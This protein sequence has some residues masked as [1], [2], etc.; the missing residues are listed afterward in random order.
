MKRLVL[1]ASTVLISLVC[2]AAVS[3]QVTNTGSISGSV[4]DP[5]GAVVAN[6]AV[7]AKNAET[8]IENSA[9]T[10][11]NGTFTI[12][13][14]E[15][16]TYRITVQATS[17]FKRTEITNV[18]VNV[19]S[20]TTVKVTMELGPPQETVTIVGGGE[21]LQTQ[22]ANVGSTITGRQ[23]TELPFTSRDALDLVLTL[24]GTQTPA[25]PRS[26]TINGLPKGALNITLDGLPD[27]AEDSKSSDG[28]FTFVR[29][30]I[31]AIEEVSLSSAVPGAE[32]SGDGA[33]QIKFS[34]R[35]G[36]SEYHGSAY[37]YHRNTALNANYYFNNISGQPRQA[38]LL[39]QPGGRVG[40][41][42]LIPKLLK[43]RDKAF[44]FVNYEEFRLPGSTARQRNVLTPD[45]QQGIFRYG[46]NSVN[47][48][49]L[50][51][52]KGQ[53]STIDPTIATN[54]SAIRASLS[55]GGLT[56]LGD[57]QQRFTWN[58]PAAQVR[59]F[60]TVRLDFNLT[61]KH[62]LD[63][64]WNYNVFRSS[65]D[66][67]NGRDPIF[68]G[69]GIG[70]GGQYSLR[71]SDSLGL[72]STLKPNL[73]NEF[74]AGIGTGGTVLF[75]PETNAGAFAPLGGFAPSFTV[76]APGGNSTSSIFSGS[77]SSRNNAPSIVFSDNVSYVRGEHSLNFGADYAQ[78]K[79]WSQN[80][81]RVVPAITFGLNTNDPAQMS[82]MFA[83]ANFPGASGTDI[84]NAQNLYA[85]LTGRVITIT[86]SAF[87]S[88]DT[89]KYTYLGDFVQRVR[90]RRMGYYAQDA[91]RFRPNLTINAGLRWEIQF[92]FTVLNDNFT[93]AGYAGVWGVS[94]VGNLFKP[95]TLAGSV[96]QFNKF[97]QK[98]HAFPTDWNNLGPSFG[99][100]WSPNAQ[101]GFLRHLIGESGQTVLRGGYSI[102]F[103]REGTDVMNS[104]T[105]GNPGGTL[106]A[107]RSVALGN[108]TAG[109]LFRNRADLAPP[110]IPS[111]PVFP[112][113]PTSIPPY[114]VNDSV[115]AFDPNLR[116]GYVQSWSAGI[117]RE[118][119]RDTVVE[120]RYVGNRGLKL[121]RQFDINETNITENGFINEFK[122]A[123]QNL[124]L[125]IQHGCGNT[126]RYFG[127]TPSGA[128][129]ACTGT[130]PLPT[131]VRYFSGNVNPNLATSYTSSNFS[132]T[133]FVNPLFPNNANARG[134][135]QSLYGDATRRANA[136]AAGLASNLFV[137]NP[138]LIGGGAFLV[139][140]GGHTWYDSLQIELR[141]RMAR[142]LLIQGSYTFSKSLSNMYAS[143]GVVFFQPGTFRDQSLDRNVSP[144]DLRHGI[145]ANWIWELPVGRGQW[146][147]GGASNLLDKV[148]GGWA[149]HGQV[150]SQ[151]GSTFNLG[152]VQLVGMTKEELQK[153]V[154]IRQDP[155]GVVFFL[156]NDI[157]LNTRR[158][159]NVTATGY[160]SLGAP[161]GKYIA[162][163]GSNGCVQTF[164][165]QCGFRNLVLYGPKLNRAD[166]S[167]VKK[168]NISER[169][170]FELRAELLNAFNNINFKVG[171]QTAEATSV[172]NFS[173]A[174]FG[175]T[176]AAYQDLSTTNDVGGR[177][178]QIVLRINF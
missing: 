6:A 7:T 4:T 114:S 137:V 178:I 170:N 25:R 50:A 153:S 129:A 135:A 5:S 130:S 63:N 104:I 15:R 51:A 2:V 154:E 159:F 14:V 117:Q 55:Q 57:N 27:Q 75:F 132:S 26:S 47:L 37:W 21:V 162:P 112:I 62:H 16:G 147:A 88:E 53:T 157:I 126:F 77:G 24:P 49:T 141:R 94:G 13:R 56:T 167:V 85:L 149:I 100:A 145:K 68:P 127:A 59:K 58:S 32:S 96:T 40:G 52:S 45:A 140:N 103:V 173:G 115:N 171:S 118:L 122:L 36:T 30:R 29:P 71:F 81:S 93:D 39:N 148:I 90:Q 116:T 99:F 121:W 1:F 48:L 54:L 28:F 168:T 142:G 89:G 92:P 143:S 133:T 69:L 107:T 66:Q 160:S 128:T 3:A 124:L 151:S 12:P 73:V 78:Y 34:T 11:E 105:G 176:T 123:Q 109:T 174:T 177:M 111:A 119:T 41:P 125:N 23:I 101:S 83:A 91:W 35:S 165:G 44:F 65:P 33:I 98:T 102:A 22:T 120:V 17:G 144:W 146:L 76:F 131:I 134:F 20:P 60:T 113:T 97:P 108:L 42:I 31:D 79:P 19:G 172:T 155:S 80:L 10:S 38:M 166:I 150:R 86:A 74:R 87:T 152:N 61:S 175:Q 70:T 156:S 164:V 64:V 72:R 139:D 46:S 169:V 43:S 95:G 67:L 106:N 163:A 158:A 84:T 161:T 136:A 110:A 8:G 82:G 18:T 9:T 138:N